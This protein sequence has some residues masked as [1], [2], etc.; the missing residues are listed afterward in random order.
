MNT[1]QYFNSL[2]EKLAAS[3]NVN[4]ESYLYF[5][6]TAYLGIPQNQQF[7]K[8]YVDGIQRYGLNN[9]TSRGNNVQLGIYNEA[10]AYIANKYGVADALITSS[11]YLAAK[12]AVEAYAQ[13]GE[14]RYAPQTHPALWKS[15]DPK[16]RGTF[17]TWTTEIVAEINNSDIEDWVLISNSMNN[18][19]PEIYDFG[20]LNQI[21]F[22]KNVVLIVD[23]SHGIGMLNNGTSVLNSLPNAAHIK[24]VVVASMAKALGVD[25]GVILGAKEE[26]S[27]LK[28]GEVFYGASPPAAA[29][30]YAFINAEDIYHY[31]YKKLQHNISFFTE[32]LIDQSDWHFIPCF[33]VFLCKHPGV[34]E[35]LLQKN[36]LISSFP[37]PDR[38]SNVLNRIVISCWHS[39]DDILKL[40][41]A[42]QN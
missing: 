25:A 21:D 24:V 19:Y 36:I 30:L 18:L 37:Y 14:V 33:P 42:L 15:D 13:H 38:N 9:G 27:K 4:H 3:I 29:G 12:L 22:R 26:I 35:K 8:F 32:K 40:L 17:A 10:E 34:A 31:T 23:D 1:T 16:I 6:G 28:Q 39:E 2:D 20:F 7:I 41:A 5:G 11:G